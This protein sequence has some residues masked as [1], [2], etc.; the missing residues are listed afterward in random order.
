L[1]LL[2]SFVAFPWGT[3]YGT[4]RDPEAENWSLKLDAMTCSF[5]FS[6]LNMKAF[7]LLEP[8][9]ILQIL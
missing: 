1:F 3:D 4:K 7:L 5:S 6:G 9:A 2:L 8:D